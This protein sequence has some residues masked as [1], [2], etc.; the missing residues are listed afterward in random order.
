[1]KFEI[2]SKDIRLDLIYSFI[3]EDQIMKS[4]QALLSVLSSYL[5]SSML[6]VEQRVRLLEDSYRSEMVKYGRNDVQDDNVN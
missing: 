1:M 3:L 2:L 6:V 5:A 4:L